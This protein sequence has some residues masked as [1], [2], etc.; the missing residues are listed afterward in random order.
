MSFI[1]GRPSPFFKYFAQKRN[2]RRGQS[3]QNLLV[4]FAT[5]EE[6]FHD[7]LGTDG[8]TANSKLV[9]EKILKLVIEEI[10]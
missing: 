9:F 7:A 1:I 10:P 5:G 2:I 3:D 4:C 6:C 8:T